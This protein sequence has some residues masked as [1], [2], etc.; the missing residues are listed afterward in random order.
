MGVELVHDN[1]A[2]QGV[3]LAPLVARHYP[4]G[5]ACGAHQGDEGRRE[6]LAKPQPGL[7]QEGV[8][9][10]PG[11]Q[12]RRLQG[13]TEGL[14]REHLQHRL[15]QPGIAVGAAAQLRRQ[16]QGP[17][18][19]TGGQAQVDLPAPVRQTGIQHR[20]GPGFHPVQ[21]LILHLCRREQQVIGTAH[22]PRR[23]GAGVAQA[24]QPVLL[25]GRHDDLVTQRFSLGRHRWRAALAGGDIVVAQAA[26][27]ALLQAA[28][29]QA[30]PVQRRLGRNVA[31]EL[32]PERHLIG[33]AQAGNI[34]GAHEVTDPGFG[35]V[36]FDGYRPQRPYARKQ[37]E[38]HQHQGQRLQYQDACQPDG[39]AVELVFAGTVQGHQRRGHQH[40]IEQRVQHHEQVLAEQEL[41]NADKVAQEQQHVGI[42]APVQL[43]Q[44]Q[45]E[46]GEQQGHGRLQAQ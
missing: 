46:G 35:G 12:Q 2:I 32:H 31:I 8:H 33:L 38:Q 5:H 41:G 36:A 11:R 20:V 34:T 14:L 6:M 9:L 40:D 22:H 21:A 3:D 1:G 19:L 17:G 7:E 15:H 43:D 45:G 18:I 29:H 4:G 24:V 44:F 39:L 16:G 26:P 27:G 30:A 23:H 10:V 13:I 25:G 42:L 28:E 37:E